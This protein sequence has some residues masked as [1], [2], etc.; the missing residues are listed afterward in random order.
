M[1]LAGLI[2]LLWTGW[3]LW[4]VLRPASPYATAPLNF[5]SWEN[6][7]LVASGWNEPCGLPFEVEPLGDGQYA[8]RLSFR[9]PVYSGPMGRIGLDEFVRDFALP[10][11]GIRNIGF[12]LERE[13]GLD[14]PWQDAVPLRLQAGSLRL[15]DGRAFN[16]VDAEDAVRGR[17]VEFQPRNDDVASSPTEFGE[18]RLITRSSA[19]LYLRG[20]L[21]FLPRQR[22]E[23]ATPPLGSMVIPR[24]AGTGQHQGATNLF[25][26]EGRCTYPLASAP[27]R[28]ID[29]LGKAHETS[30]TT[31][32]FALFAASVLVGVGAGCL[33][34]ATQSTG[35]GAW[36]GAGIAAILFGVAS[37]FAI[38]I[39]P[40]H[41][42]DE[43]RHLLSFARL[44]KNPPTF[45]R[46]KDFG[47]KQ[48]YE[49][50]KWRPDEK[51]S[52]TTLEQKEGFYLAESTLDPA[53]I[54]QFIQ[55]YWWR[56]PAVAW[57]WT[58][59]ARAGAESRI[60]PL[61][62]VLRVI[63]ALLGSVI[64]GVA[65]AVFAS[66]LRPGAGRWIIAA[67]LIICSL[68][69]LAGA[70]TNYALLTTTAVA[71]GALLLRQAWRFDTSLPV[72]LLTGL[73]V[74]LLFHISLNAIPAIAGV[75]LWLAHRPILRWLGWEHPEPGNPTH[76][77]IS[78][79]GALALGFLATRFLS[80]REFNGQV[81]QQFKNLTGVGFAGEWLGEP[82]VLWGVVCAT[83]AV[84]EWATHRYWAGTRARWLPLLSRWSGYATWGVAALL[85][86]NAIWF[87]VRPAPILPD[88]EQPWRQYPG[89]PSSGC[90]VRSIEEAGIQ[91]EGVP[92]WEHVAQVLRVTAANLTFVPQDFILVRSFWAGFLGGEARVPVWV[93]A[94]NSS[95]CVTGLALGLAA[96]ARARS[97]RR[98]M[99]VLL[100]GIAVLG[101]LAG[102]AAG[103]WPRNL[104]G[105]Y[106]LPILT[107][108]VLAAI[109][110]WFELLDHAGERRPW[111]TA[112]AVMVAL[113]VPLAAAEFAIVERFF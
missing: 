8:Q 89:I 60:G 39:A 69:A 15:P 18:V 103:Y 45:A 92:R 54:D 49:T 52:A 6:S 84:A 65:A 13:V 85:V 17:L 44:V 35:G 51:L 101:A 30:S 111:S 113:L 104:Y 33:Y 53:R 28:R 80:S 29:L 82:A 93:S 10:T 40:L 76:R 58:M 63:D 86:A 57:V 41:G 68:P 46:V 70:V 22:S 95:L 75:V 59:V 38:I 100:G 32:L 55:K 112:A 97:P 66:V 106:A 67:P 71:L 61:A 5:L 4:L 11:S 90:P 62:L 108:A 91:I 94:V 16:L 14:A 2:G 26:P 27:P 102:L 56:S 87:T 3:N 7:A 43:S 88:R 42:P 81:V 12:Y 74:G 23:Q 31:L 107:M 64:V 98:T 99:V 48:H 21:R 72:A 83:M 78:W 20:L 19:P 24:S 79:W 73:C 77:I 109:A 9:W 34:C 25:Y 96:I 105:R 110:G 47:E 50:L 1:T 37:S 36:A